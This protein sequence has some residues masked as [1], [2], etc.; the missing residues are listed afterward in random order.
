MLAHRFRSVGR[1]VVVAAVGLAALVPVGA[2]AGAGGGAWRSQPAAHAAMR[3]QPASRM[4][5]LHGLDARDGSETPA[6]Q[7]CA[8]YS[9]RVGAV[10]Q[11]QPAAFI[12]HGS[13]APSARTGIGARTMD[14]RKQI[15]SYILTNFLFSDDDSAIADGDSLIR[16]GVI[17]STGFAELVFHLEDVFAFSVTDEE[18]IPANFDSIDSIDAFVAR[19]RAG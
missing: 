7:R 17:D 8:G 1:A 11:T 5:G 10:L 4:N 3:I 19:K 14:Q 6:R 9:A 13:A 2:A 16:N 18:M 12:S 15:K